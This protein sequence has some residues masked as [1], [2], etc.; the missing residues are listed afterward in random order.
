MLV[1]KCIDED[2]ES[3]SILGALTCC[4]LLRSR[5]MLSLLVSVALLSLLPTTQTSIGSRPGVRDGLRHSHVTMYVHD[6]Q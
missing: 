4:D 6:V 5:L 2:T 3:P 1:P